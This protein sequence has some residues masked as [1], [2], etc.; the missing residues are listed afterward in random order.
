MGDVRETLP[1]P[2]HLEIALLRLDTDF[3]E[4]THHELAHL[5]DL[6]GERGVVLI[7]DYGTWKG[8]TSGGG[9][10][11]AKRAVQPFLHR[12]S[13]KERMLVK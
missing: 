5:Y 4:S 1:N 12:T 9:E 13:R 10:F 8:S 11:F 6:V 2:D 7:D 3:Y